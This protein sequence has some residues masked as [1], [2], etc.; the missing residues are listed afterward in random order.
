MRPCNVWRLLS[1]ECHDR[2]RA[3]LQNVSTLANI[4]TNANTTLDSCSLAKEAVRLGISSSPAADARARAEAR[5]RESKKDITSA[6]LGAVLGVAAALAAAATAALLCLRRRRRRKRSD[7]KRADAE[8]AE[9]TCA[10]QSGNL[11][12]ASGGNSDTN[13]AAHPE[14]E[15]L[16][17]QNHMAYARGRAD[18]FTGSELTR[19]LWTHA[20]SSAFASTQPRGVTA[21]LTDN[22]LVTRSATAS[23]SPSASLP[24]QLVA[25][26][27]QAPPHAESQ[28]MRG[29]KQE[30]HATGSSSAES[31]TAAELLA[32]LEKAA[33]AKPRQVIA[34]RYVLL[35]ERV[36]TGQAVVN[37][38][39]SQAGDFR[40]FAI[41]CA[42]TPNP[43]RRWAKCVWLYAS[44]QHH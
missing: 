35:R 33:S 27:Q 29:V 23:T 34:G 32:A 28:V 24:A 18:T 30:G 37:F 14:L 15:P 5:S 40:Q 22:A 13:L 11:K 3:A 4:T 19:G 7:A 10:G 31:D 38:A 1:A 44:V 16:H 17:V 42:L 8:R 39:V 43:N 6:L 21:T 9:Q 12:C 20:T 41:K 36:A 2:M 26:A 25:G